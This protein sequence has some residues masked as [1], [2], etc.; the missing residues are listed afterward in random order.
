MEQWLSLLCEE[1]HCR[2]S[3]ALEEWERAPAGLLERIVEFRAF[4]RAKQMYEQA[5]TP[6]QQ[7]ALPDDPMI[8]LVRELDFAD[9]QAAI[10]A[11]KAT[12]H[13]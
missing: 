12:R 7:A 13:A 1:F 10:D 5:N 8:D 11:A 6:E 4:A 9:G 3:E 2:P